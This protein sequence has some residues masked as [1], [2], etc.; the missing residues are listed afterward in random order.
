[1]RITR[2]RLV[3]FGVPLVALAGIAVLLAFLVSGGAQPQTAQ[4]FPLP[5]HLKPEDFW[6]EQQGVLHVVAAPTEG[7]P[8]ASSGVAQMELWFDPRNMRA[9]QEVRSTD[10]FLDYVAVGDGD[11]YDS[12]DSRTK[13]VL[14]RRLLDGGGW[15][16]WVQNDGS[17]VMGEAFV[18]RYPDDVKRTTLNGSDVLSYQLPEIGEDGQIEATQTMYLDSTTRLPVRSEREGVSGGAKTSGSSVKYAIVEWLPQEQ[19]EAGLFRL[20][21]DLP[22]VTSTTTETHMTLDEAAKFNDFDI[23]YLGDVFQDAGLCALFDYETVSKYESIHYF[24][25]EYSW[26]GTTARV[27]L[28]VTS[29]PFVEGQRNPWSTPRS[30]S[31]GPMN[32]IVQ[33]QPA[34]FY[35][36]GDL[37]QRLGDTI[38]HV[39]STDTKFATQEAITGIGQELKRLNE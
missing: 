28:H 10:G 18:N 27:A 25:A 15:G 19:V 5:Q 8:A 3:V 4:S 7:S 12:Y 30:G 32:I 24:A 9:C 21:V 29:T 13:S 26:D 1:M 37:W 35:D 22:D 31:S 20:P 11:H 23:Y 34:L 6:P 14:H 36:P 33:G 16:Y 17:L 2:F 39:S 38:V